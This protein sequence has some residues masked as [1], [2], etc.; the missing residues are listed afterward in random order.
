MNK[1][2]TLLIICFLISVTGM[3]AATRKKKENKTEQKK[4]SEYDKLFGTPACKTVKGMIT[5]HKID[6]KVYFEFPF[7]LFGKE[8]L[9]GS[10]VEEIS[11]NTEALVG[12]KPH[13]PPC[14]FISQR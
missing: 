12:Q 2:I 9:L 3:Q 4:Q 14:T 8:M 10:T 1:I 13:A 5:L 7:S 11:D 6:G